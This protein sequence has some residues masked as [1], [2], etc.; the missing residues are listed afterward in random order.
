MDYYSTKKALSQLLLLQLCL[1]G[2]AG[3]KDQQNLLPESFPEGVDP[4]QYALP[5][6]LQE[7][8]DTFAARGASAILSCK[9]AHALKAHFTCNDEEV[10]G[11]EEDLIE[12]GVKLKRLSIEVSRSDLHLVLGKFTCRCHASSAQ[13]EVVSSEAV[14]K[15][16][17]LR[18]DFD[19]PPYSQQIELGS[20]AQLRCHPPKGSPA[21]RVIGWQKNGVDI[22]DPNFIASTDGHLILIQ[23][24]M[25]DAGN[26]TCLASNDVLTRSSPPAQLT[27]YGKNN[28][29]LS[30]TLGGFN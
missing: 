6:F 18:K 24:R 3:A 28:H 26:Y 20:Q 10:E 22:N 1:L 23:A 5:V 9:A 27:V 13:G 8:Q 29:F 7:P 21:A 15:S 2:L 4:S 12:N 17:Y 30:K 14:V 11:T 16:A 19:T 25:E